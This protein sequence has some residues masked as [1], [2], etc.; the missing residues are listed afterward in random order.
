MQVKSIAE[1]SVEHSAIFSTF[2]KLPIV[3]KMVVLSI[4]E[5]SFYTGFTV[6]RGLTKMVDM[7]YSMPDPVFLTTYNCVTS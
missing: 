5:W 2:I 6:F 4:F 1:C 7:T 3:I